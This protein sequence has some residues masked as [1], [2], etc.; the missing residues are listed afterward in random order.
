MYTLVTWL[1]KFLK[2]VLYSDLTIKHAE[3][4]LWAYNSRAEKKVF[5]I[6]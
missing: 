5:D 2:F 1:H 6:L 3:I 4:I